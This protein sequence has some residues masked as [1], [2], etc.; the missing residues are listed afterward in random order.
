MDS[1]TIHFIG[2]VLFTSQVIGP[3]TLVMETRTAVRESPAQVNTQRAATPDGGIQPQ[4]RVEP[5]AQVRPSNARPSTP[6]PVNPQQVVAILPRVAPRFVHGQQ[7]HSSRVET[8]T[9]MIVFEKEDLVPSSMVGWVEQP[10]KGN[11]SYIELTGEHL[12]FVADGVN[13]VAT[14][15]QRLGK[16]GGTLLPAYRPPYYSGASGVFFIPRGT[17][18][19]CV[20]STPGVTG[21][22]DTKLA[23]K[24]LGT[25]TIKGPDKKSVTFKGDARV[26][27]AN[28]P[29]AWAKSQTQTT[30]GASHHTVYCAM[31]GNTK[32]D[33]TVVEPKVTG[34]PL[35]SCNDG[36]MKTAEIFNVVTTDV[37]CSNSQWP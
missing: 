16:A 11:F 6:V 37:F 29:F 10:L 25:L 1:A 17:L 20:S 7:A 34:T 32:C 27:V 30:G 5:R 22:I 14:R 13:G 4:A 31:T 26:F 21:R 19:A 23:L 2:L 35:A 18:T 24:N 9:A 8:H 33:A 36:N 3:Q 12:S 28:V 15:D